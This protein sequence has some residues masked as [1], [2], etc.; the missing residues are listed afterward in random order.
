MPSEKG[1]YCFEFDLSGLLR[2]DK[3]TR[4]ACYALALQN[5]QWMTEDEVR[6]QEGMPPLTDEQREQL[7]P[8]PEPVEDDDQDEDD[9]PQEQDGADTEEQFGNKDQVTS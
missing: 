3:K 8:A 6:E 4:Y 7:A 5:K 1:K 2:G 9:E